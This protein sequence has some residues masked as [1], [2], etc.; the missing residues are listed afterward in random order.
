VVC[1][2]SRWEKRAGGRAGCGGGVSCDERL[3]RAVLGQA[4]RRTRVCLCGPKMEDWVSAV[5]GVGILVVICC[6]GELARLVA[7]D[8]EKM[9]AEAAGR[10]PAQPKLYMG[11]PMRMQFKTFD[12]S[13]KKKAPRQVAHIGDLPSLDLSDT[14]L[15]DN[16]A[17]AINLTP[18]DVNGNEQLLSASELAQ[19]APPLRRSPCCCAR[20]RAIAVLE[21]RRQQVRHDL[22]RKHVW[23]AVQSP[24]GSM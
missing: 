22:I 15:R 1:F 6:C 11:A 21:L 23:V 13:K 24:E 5:I 17:S 18:R 16:S 9:A 2:G 7:Q 3:L 4:S 10:N 19:G 8:D 12:V 14:N 20:H